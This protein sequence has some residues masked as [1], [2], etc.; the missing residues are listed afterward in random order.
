MCRFIKMENGEICRRL[1][2]QL[3]IRTRAVLIS[4][5]RPIPEISLRFHAMATTIPS[6]GHSTDQAG[7]DP[8][9]SPPQARIHVNG[10]NSLRT[11][12]P[13]LMKLFW[14][15][16]IPDLNTKRR[17]G[18]DPRGEIPQRS[19]PCPNLVMRE[20]RSGM[21]RTGGRE[22]LRQATETLQVLSGTAGAGRHGRVI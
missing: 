19:A 12:Q 2:P 16:S 21:K 8:R 9:R 17:C 22:R 6:I 15:N 3:P 20:W 13:H 18:V 4:H 14:S 10:L 11:R 1:L 7:A 5:M